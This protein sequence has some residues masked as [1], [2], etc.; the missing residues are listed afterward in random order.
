MRRVRDI[1]SGPVIDRHARPNDPYTPVHF[2]VVLT[3]S[4]PQVVPGFVRTDMVDCIG[5]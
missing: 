3:Q 4:R 2:I 1:V 5:L